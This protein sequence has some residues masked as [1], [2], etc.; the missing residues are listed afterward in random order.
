EGGGG[1]ERSDREGAGAPDAHQDRKQKR[2]CQEHRE[3][4]QHGR[5]LGRFG[6]VAVWAV[7]PLI[8]EG[9][10][11]G[12]VPR[13][14][15]GAPCERPTLRLCL[16]SSSLPWHLHA[17]ASRSS[18]PSW[19]VGCRWRPG[20]RVCP[21]SSSPPASTMRSS[22]CSCWAWARHPSPASR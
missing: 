21:I 1:D 17:G 4:R 19:R 8:L 15:T 11:A 22:G 18:R 9:C 12:T 2:P 14:R 20:R 7:C 13:G 3:E 5:L 16:S 6:R 10:C